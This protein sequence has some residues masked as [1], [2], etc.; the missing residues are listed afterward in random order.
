M[1]AITA[2][3]CTSH[4][5]ERAANTTS[6]VTVSTSASQLPL[7]IPPGGS[8]CLSVTL[9]HNT[10]GKPSMLYDGTAGTANTG[11]VPPS[12]V[13]PEGLLGFAGLALFVPLLATRLIRR[14][15]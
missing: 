1:A 3:L 12:I 6:P 11:L 14:R 10:G 8:L 5:Q 4:T 13:V 2:A 9:T 7:V 15:K